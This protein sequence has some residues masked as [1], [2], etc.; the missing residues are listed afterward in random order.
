MDG[1][2]PTSSQPGHQ[3]PGSTAPWGVARA[4]LLGGRQVVPRDQTGLWG[5]RHR[6]VEDTGT[7]PGVAAGTGRENL[8]TYLKL[9]AT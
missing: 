3:H 6:T 5:L 4:L 7:G 2:L 8:L 9:L 1:G